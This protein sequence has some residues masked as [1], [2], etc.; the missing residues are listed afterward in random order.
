MRSVSIAFFPLRASRRDESAK[1]ERY[2]G[3]PG[4]MPINGMD[5]WE[6]AVTEVSV[7][8]CGANPNALLQH[9]PAGVAKALGCT[10][11]G[12]FSRWIPEARPKTISPAVA[13]K[14][15]RLE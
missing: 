1:A 13:E 14:L 6:T 4:G 7:V 9:A 11:A 15:Q 2:G 5:F 8:G 10:G 3:K 12:C